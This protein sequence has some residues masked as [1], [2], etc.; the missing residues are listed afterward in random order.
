ML[1]TTLLAA[2]LLATTVQAAPPYAP[3]RAPRALAVE[4]TEHDAVLRFQQVPESRG[5][6]IEFCV[7]EDCDTFA[8]ATG[9]RLV[10]GCAEGMKAGH[11]PL[12][13]TDKPIRYRVRASKDAKC[14][15][16]RGNLGEFSETVT[17]DPL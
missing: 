6:L 17:A 13:S 1:R 14:S 5:Y 12:P 10:N 15:T 2:I 16:K 3:L 9:D 8:R 11:N 4:R 7:G